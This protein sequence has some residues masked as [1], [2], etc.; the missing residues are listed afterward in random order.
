MK[1]PRRKKKQPK[2]RKPQTLVS[3]VQSVIQGQPVSQGQ[4]A[5][6]AQQNFQFMVEQSDDAEL[7]AT[8]IAM[9]RWLFER[10]KVSHA[11]PFNRVV[12]E[13]CAVPTGLNDLLSLHWYKNDSTIYFCDFDPS[14]LPPIKM[15]SYNDLVQLIKGKFLVKMDLSSIDW[16]TPLIPI[17]GTYIARVF[18]SGNSYGNDPPWH[19]LPFLVVIDPKLELDASQAEVLHSIYNMIGNFNLRLFVKHIAYWIDE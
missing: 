2:R 14:L 9:R 4:S 15:D 19:N 16:R 10:I 13:K 17:G 8:M 1:K 11:R 12:W 6:Q 3:Q 5:S 7:L 18:S